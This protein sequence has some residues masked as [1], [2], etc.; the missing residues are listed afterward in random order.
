M[1][2][3]TQQPQSRLLA[4]V[5]ELLIGIVD[6]VES[7]YDLHS[8]A[9]V[10]SRLQGLTEP[11]LYRSILIRK[12][13]TA[14]RVFSAIMSRPARAS[15]IRQLQLRYM[16]AHRGG[17]QVLNEGLRKMCNLQELTIEAPCC[18]DAYAFLDEG[19]ESKG[20]IDYADYFIFA[21]SMTVE[22]QPR[23]QVPLQRCKFIQNSLLHPG[24]S[25]T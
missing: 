6:F 22:T 25:M 1:T 16:Y 19:F 11:A 18:N 5:D 4:L 17:I 9:L 8:L 12:G 23:V 15:F 3:V 21:S 13:T 2:Q 14:L 24:G 10:C 20:L 7:K